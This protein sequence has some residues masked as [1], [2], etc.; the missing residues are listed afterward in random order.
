M[1][2]PIRTSSTGTATRSFTLPTSAALWFQEVHFQFSYVDA[3]ANRLG[4]AL[5]DYASVVRQ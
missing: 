3:N 2:W 4:L 1:I 5:T